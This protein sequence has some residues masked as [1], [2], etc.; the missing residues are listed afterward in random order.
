M[1]KI[2]RNGLTVL[3]ELIWYERNDEKYTGDVAY[4][5]VE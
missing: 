2:L 3:N 1:G 4:R 5:F